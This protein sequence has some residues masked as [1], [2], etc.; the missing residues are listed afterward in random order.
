MT[1]RVIPSAAADFAVADFKL[2]A[3]TSGVSF[4][5]GTEFPVV[6][7]VVLTD[8]N[9]CIRLN[10]W[11]RNGEAVAV[12]EAARRTSL[13][14]VP[15]AIPIGEWHV[16][17]FF[18]I[19]QSAEFELQIKFG[20]AEPTE[21]LTRDRERRTRRGAANGGLLRFPQTRSSR[22]FSLRVSACSPTES[23]PSERSR[24]GRTSNALSS[25]SSC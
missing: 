12:S 6:A 16:S 13:G 21:P 7:L 10:K 4:D 20:E 17:F 19:P 3:A 11:V 23:T 8:P 9:D 1:V 25:S 5:F 22:L 18:P 24:P 15:G 2:E 14:G